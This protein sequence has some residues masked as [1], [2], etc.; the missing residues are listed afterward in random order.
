MSGIWQA[1]NEANW[2]LEAHA[3][4]PARDAAECLPVRVR[5]RPAA[6]V[7]ALGAAAGVPASLESSG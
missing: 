1:L 7:V 3:A 2:D 5:A 4:R 6:P